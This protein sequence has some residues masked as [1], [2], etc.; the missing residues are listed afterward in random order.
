MKS[1]IILLILIFNISCKKDD[2]NPFAK[3]KT[4]INELENK[5]IE[6]ISE[7]RIKKTFILKVN[8]EKKEY[9]FSNFQKINYI[10]NDQNE[11]YLVK[12]LKYNINKN[13]MFYRRIKLEKL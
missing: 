11:K 4:T 6:F 13:N 5:E 2:N 7:N 9:Q 1:L 10:V 12:Y 3:Y 8:N